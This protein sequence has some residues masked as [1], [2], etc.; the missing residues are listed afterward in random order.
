VKH[1]ISENL[2]PL[3]HRCDGFYANMPGP[4]LIVCAWQ[5]IQNAGQIHSPGSAP[6]SREKL[7]TVLETDS[8]FVE[9]AGL[10]ARDPVI[11]RDRSFRFKKRDLR[12]NKR[13]R[14]QKRRLGN[15]KFKIQKSTAAHALRQSG[16]FCRGLIQNSIFNLSD[17][18]FYFQ[19]QPC[20]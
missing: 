19:D 15:S 12:S 4:C 5:S 7:E 18:L 9:S 10:P 8:P 6:G 3:F 2:P 13:G 20:L 11:R 1:V 17:A 14:E 16:M